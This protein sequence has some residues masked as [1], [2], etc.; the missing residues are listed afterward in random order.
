MRRALLAAAL[1]LFAGRVWSADGCDKF[2]WSIARDRSFISA[3]GQTS[4]AAAGETLLE[5]PVRAVLVRLGPSG[6]GRF[7]LAPERP[8]APGTFGGAVHLPPIT[9]AGIYQV[10]LSHDAWL[11][12]VQEGRHAR[13]VGSSGRRDC[14]TSERV[15]ALS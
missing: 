14:P 6:E 8:P 15:S 13:A 4:V 10:T 7:V 12:V 2:A 5:F 9:K 3:P 11:D 1:A